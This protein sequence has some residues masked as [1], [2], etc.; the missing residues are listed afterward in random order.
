MY[1]DSLE[2]EMCRVCLSLASRGPGFRMLPI[3]RFTGNR[4]V[5]NHLV[6]SDRQ[7]RIRHVFYHRRGQNWIVD[8]TGEEIWLQ[9]RFEV[10]ALSSIWL[11]G[12]KAASQILRKR[13]EIVWM[14]WLS[15]AEGEE[16]KEE[17]TKVRESRL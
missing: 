17:N 13:V 16:D 10:E 14:H 11:V 5:E 8:R 12:S 3:R 4:R 6:Q 2:N 1:F 15:S 7:C 9:A